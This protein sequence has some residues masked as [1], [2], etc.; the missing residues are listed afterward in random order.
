MAFVLMLALLG[1]C[2]APSVAPTVTAPPSASPA[3]PREETLYLIEVSTG[4]R[5]LAN[6]DTDPM[7]GWGIAMGGGTCS[8]NGACWGGHYEGPVHARHTVGESVTLDLW[9]ELVAPAAS[10]LDLVASLHQD[11]DQ[12]LSASATQPL[13]PSP[14]GTPAPGNEGCIHLQVEGA[15]T[16]DLEEKADMR[17]DL[18]VDGMDGAICTGGGTEGN[19]LHFNGPGA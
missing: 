17:L 9:V 19:R 8:G 2:A 12:V 10:P 18:R 1:G 5:L 15:L 14:P 13:Q 16:K 7:E 3:Q 6:P 4:D 11:R